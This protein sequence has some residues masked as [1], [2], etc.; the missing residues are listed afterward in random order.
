VRAIC[1]E[2][3][4]EAHEGPEGTRFRWVCN[5][6]QIGR[7]MSAPLTCQYGW[8]KH[9]QLTRG[10]LN[11]SINKETAPCSNDSPTAPDG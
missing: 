8:I 9:R 7:W 2:R 10:M 11:R 6:G 5:C 4:L 3:M 1:L